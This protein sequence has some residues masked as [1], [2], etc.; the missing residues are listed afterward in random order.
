MHK[1]DYK[2]FVISAS[3]DISAKV[4]A[5]E[6]FDIPI[7]NTAEIRLKIANGKFT[8]VII[9]P[10]PV[11]SGKVKQFQNLCDDC[12]PMVVATDSLLDFPILEICDPEGIVLLVG[13]YEEL[14]NRVLKELTSTIQVYTIPNATSSTS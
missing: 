1:L 10:I 2:I 4:A 13:E 9:K 14:L 6:L 3:N 12:N 5:N 11:G 7:E 8:N